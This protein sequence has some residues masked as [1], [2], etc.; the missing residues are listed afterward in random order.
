MENVPLMTNAEE[1][2]LPFGLVTFVKISC[3]I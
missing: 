3:D 2:K 1:I